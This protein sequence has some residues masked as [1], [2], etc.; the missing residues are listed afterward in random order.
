MKGIL[1]AGGS[2]TRLYPST[3]AISKQLIPVYDK[4]MVYYPLSV[5]MLCDIRDILIITTQEDQPNFKR[6]LGDGS[7][8]GIH[9]SYCIQEKPEG[10]AQAFILAEDFIS[11]EPVCLILGD[12][13]FYCDSL[14]QLM[15]DAM[16]LKEGAHVFA[17]HV[18]TPEN[19]GVAAFNENG[20]VIDIIEK[21]AVPPSAW[22]ITGLYFYDGE[23]S[24][25][26]KKLKPSARGE[27]EITDL[28]REYLK[29][30]KLTLH[31]L[32]RGAA[33]LDTGS[34]DG[35][36]EAAH[37]VQVLEKRQGL[38]IASPEEVAWRKGFIDAQQL[39]TLAN[40]TQKSG[41]GKYLKSLLE[42]GYG[43]S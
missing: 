28:S 20:E 6:L 40:K 8:W 14:S 30:K 5:L 38:K 29:K 17:Y 23:V 12:N 11:H 3:L 43:S 4:P 21:P 19:Y 26:A 2:G 22:A 32:P 9:L 18:K 33:W 10:I 42:D 25:I 36:L 31:Y 13:I 1:L 15:E 39:L 35:M 24:S 37:F 16:N 34:F 7:Q 41:Y 27:L